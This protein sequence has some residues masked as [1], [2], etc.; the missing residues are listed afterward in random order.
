VRT[1]QYSD[2]APQIFRK[3][4]PLTRGT[5]GLLL[6]TFGGPPYEWLSFRILLL[7]KRAKIKR[8]KS[9]NNSFVASHHVLYTVFEET[10]YG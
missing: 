6:T 8:K 5:K 1:S 7:L 2:T 9:K 4:P 3:Y 10:V